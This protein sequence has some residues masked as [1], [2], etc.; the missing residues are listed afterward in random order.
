MFCFLNC[1]IQYVSIS[2]ALA[3]DIP[4]LQSLR[5]SLRPAMLRSSLCDGPAFVAGLTAVYQKLWQRY[6]HTP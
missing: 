1:S 6:C 2:V 3:G 5:A 4:A